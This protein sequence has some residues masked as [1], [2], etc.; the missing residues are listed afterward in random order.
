M[1]LMDIK[2]NLH[3]PRVLALLSY[4][5]YAPTEEKLK[6]LVDDFASDKDVYAFSCTQGDA[7]AGL[8]LLKR[9]QDASFEI[10]GIAV[11]PFFRG[12]GIG[13]AMIHETAKHLSCAEIYA[14]TDDDAV[15]FYKQCG[16]TVQALG[17]KYPGVMR[18]LCTLELF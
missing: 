10:L 3:D 2:G 9:W 1:I 8:I 14:E 13:T 7:L 18:Y 16:F 15:M 17:E 11:D 12:R 5:Q 6:R 4:C